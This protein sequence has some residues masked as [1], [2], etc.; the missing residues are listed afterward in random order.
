[1][2]PLTTDKEIISILVTTFD[3]F[4]F[5]G[6]AGASVEELIKILPPSKW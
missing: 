2:L 3:G 4:L 5:T 6:G 1:M